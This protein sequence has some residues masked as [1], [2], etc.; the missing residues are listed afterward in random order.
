MRMMIELMI[1]HFFCILNRILFC[2]LT[3]LLLLLLLL[4]GCGYFRLA[5]WQLFI[6]HLDVELTFDRVLLC[7]S[8]PEG[9]WKRWS[10]NCFWIRISS[11]S[12][13]LSP[14]YLPCLCQLNLIMNINL[15]RISLGTIDSTK[16]WNILITYLS[17]FLFICHF[18]CNID[19]S[20]NIHRL[21]Y[22][23]QFCKLRSY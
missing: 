10:A 22:V 7:M 20:I 14:N 12:L 16:R 3:C 8:F 23:A 21:M 9:S 18:F 11:Q 5:D 19:N 15:H 6:I 17:N 4:I 1:F 13:F 2:I